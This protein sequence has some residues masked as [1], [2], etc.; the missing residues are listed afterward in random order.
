GRRV[1]PF[2][3]DTYEKVLGPPR[4][5]LLHTRSFG[6]NQ[7]WSDYFN[8]IGMDANAAYRN[9]MK[10]YILALPER[11]GNPQDAIVKGTVYWIYD[12]NPQWKSNESYRYGVKELLSFTNPDPEVQRRYRERG[13]EDPPAIP[14]PGAK[15]GQR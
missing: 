10:D 13:G 1:D 4:Y 11:T 9:P 5:D 2:T 12:K 15:I 8:R 3:V 6:Y 14:R 7:I